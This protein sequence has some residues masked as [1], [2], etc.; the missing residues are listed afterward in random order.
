MSDYLLEKGFTYH[1]KRFKPMC[2]TPIGFLTYKKHKLYILSEGK[3]R[4][5]TAFP[6]GIKGKIKEISRVVERITRCEPQ[7]AICFDGAVIVA[8]RHTIDTFGLQDG[9]LIKSEE[10]RKSYI[11][12]D[13]LAVISGVKGFESCVAYG[14]Y[15]GNSKREEVCVFAKSSINEDWKKVFEFPAGA[16]R[17][18]HS[19]VPD[20]ANECVYILTGDED[21]ESG[22]WRATNNFSTVEPVAVGNQDY[23]CC[24]AFPSGKTLTYTTDIPSRQNYIT[25]LN[26]TDCEIEKLV[27]LPGSCTVGCD[28]DG[29]KIFCTSVESIEPS[30]RGKLD[31]IKYLLNRKLGQGIKDK[32]PRMYVENA[33]GSFKEFLKC[34][35][36]NWPGGLCRF[37][38]IYPVYDAIN[39]RLYVFPIAVKKYDGRLYSIDLEKVRE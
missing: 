11:H 7:Y 38:R 25:R 8:R 26:L 12:T 10:Y 24:I 27:E 37:G 33:D 35:K 36:D 22:I 17:H 6:C 1:G 19:I 2:M 39:K 15:F 18:I 9:S 3:F 34:E 29:T 23:R 13:R 4:L 21:G 30:S 31:M 16:V 14:E 5:F 20:A 32:F 28:A